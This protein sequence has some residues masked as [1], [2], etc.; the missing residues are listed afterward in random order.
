MDNPHFAAS[1]LIPSQQVWRW[2]SSF[3]TT[4]N[5]DFTQQPL[6]LSLSLSIDH[7]SI[8]RH[9][10]YNSVLDL[11]RITFPAKSLCF[12]DTS[13]GFNFA[14]RKHKAQS[15]RTYQ[16]RYQNLGFWSGCPTSSHISGSQNQLILLARS[17]QNKGAVVLS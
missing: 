9:N 7:E 13:F 16:N 8:R 11:D 15:S 10:L 3:P 1:S 14:P 2:W 4:N 12:L 5:E 17:S 6:S